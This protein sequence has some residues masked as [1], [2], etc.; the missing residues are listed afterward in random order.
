MLNSLERRQAAV[1]HSA[2]E[3]LGLRLVHAANGLKEE[4][5]HGKAGSL[6]ASNPWPLGFLVLVGAKARAAAHAGTTG[7]AQGTGAAAP[8]LQH[9]VAK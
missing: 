1:Q 2:Q 4:A 3:N 9:H 8:D 5:Q 6:Q 7:T